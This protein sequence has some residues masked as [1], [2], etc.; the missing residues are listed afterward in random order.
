MGDEKTHR[1]LQ[2]L[3]KCIAEAVKYGSENQHNPSIEYLFVQKA[4]PFSKLASIWNCRRQ[5]NVMNIV[6]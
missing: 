3:A 1:M 2:H 5:K 6:W 4:N